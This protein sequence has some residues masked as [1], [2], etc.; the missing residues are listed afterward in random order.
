M[1]QQ[2][3][4]D[5][6]CVFIRSCYYSSGAV[7]FGDAARAW[8]GSPMLQRVIQPWPN[9][10]APKYRYFPALNCAPKSIRWLRVE[11][12][13]CSTWKQPFASCPPTV[14]I[15]SY[16]TLL[17]STL[18]YAL[19]LSCFTMPSNGIR[20]STKYYDDEYEYRYVRIAALRE[21]ANQPTNQPTT[22]TTSSSSR[23][24][25]SLSSSSLPLVHSHVH[26]PDDIA[27]VL[28]RNRLLSE[29]EWRS[30]GVTQSLGWVHYSIHGPEPHILLFRRPIGQYCPAPSEAERLASLM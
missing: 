10:K 13:C 11:A 2:Q 16:S 12:R 30:L 6:V 9:E 7:A 20:Y 24:S 18:L 26:L 23:L 17:Y 19:S 21:T 22:S 28:P 27:K 8:L 15:S 14:R 1:Q 29:D 5:V 3:Q 25:N 4:L